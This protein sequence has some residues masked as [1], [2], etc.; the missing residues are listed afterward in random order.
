MG[1]QVVTKVLVIRLVIAGDPIFRPEMRRAE[2]TFIEMLWS[3]C[4]GRGVGP[5]CQALVGGVLQAVAS[6]TGCVSILERPIVQA[7]WRQNSSRLASHGLGVKNWAE[8]R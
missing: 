4:P 6:W 1:L 8:T 2:V 3:A 5:D 7:G